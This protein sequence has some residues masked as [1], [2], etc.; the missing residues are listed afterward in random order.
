MRGFLL[1]VCLAWMALPACREQSE[2]QLGSKPLV[3]V[4]MAP[5]RFL[6]SRIAGDK[7]DVAVV[8][9]AGQS[10]GT[11]DPTPKQLIELSKASAYFT[12]GVEIERSVVKRLSEGNPSMRIVD[13]QQG[14]DLMPSEY[15]DSHDDD[16][17]GGHSESGVAEHD[18]DHGHEHEAGAPDPHTWLDP[19]LFAKQGQNVAQALALMD[20]PH[21][22]EYQAAADALELELL[23]LDA[24]LSEVLKPLRGTELYVYHSAYAYFARRYGLKQVAIESGGQE[25]GAEYLARIT[26]RAKKAGAKVIFVQPQYSKA[27]ASSIAETI[28]AAVVPMDHMSEAY[29]DEL[30]KMAKSIRDYSAPR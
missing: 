29:M 6:V 13:L 4:S 8:L 25:P 7:M 15:G 14:I 12:V 2:P 9:P 16:H 22:A 5:H 18:H 28:Q 24:E 23:G 17:G 3:A 11:Y 21:A 10:H 1:T 30:R 19:V 27:Q 20:P 26:D